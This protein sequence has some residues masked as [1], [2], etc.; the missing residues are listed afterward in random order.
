VRILLKAKD[1]DTSL[2]NVE[3]KIAAE[4]SKTNEIS[5]VFK[6]YETKRIYLAA[7]TDGQLDSLR[8][9]EEEDDRQ[10]G[11]GGI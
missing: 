4:C 9:E 3:S 10:D 1:I 2:R 11:G 8:E 7:K 6:E 5:M